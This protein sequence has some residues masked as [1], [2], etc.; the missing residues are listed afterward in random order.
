LLELVSRRIGRRIGA[1]V[2]SAMAI[3]GIG[4]LLLLLDQTFRAQEHITRRLLGSL[5]ESVATSFRSFDARTGQHPIGDISAELADYPEIEV[6][7]VFDRHGRIRWSSDVRRRG[8]MVERELLSV[9]TSTPALDAPER[10][11]DADEVRVVLPLRKTSGCLPCHD[12]SPDPIGGLAAV[13]SN[14]KLLASVISFTR[15]AGVTVFIAVVLLTALLLF[16]LNRV[17]VTRI[18]DLVAVMTK[19]EEGDFLVRAKVSSHDEIGLLA[20]TFNKMLA[21]ITDLRVER[22]ESER[23][24]GQVLGELELERELAQKTEQLEAANVRLEQRL[25]QL[26]FLNQL[27]RDLAARLDIDYLLDLLTQRIGES[28]AVPELRVILLERDNTAK[29]TKVRGLSDDLIGR[30]L[31]TKG[32]IGEAISAR[33]SI[34]V[35]NLAGDPRRTAYGADEHGSLLVVPMMYQGLATG[36]LVFSSPMADAFREDDR[37]LFATAASQAAL[38]LANAQ[39]FQETLELSLKDGLT[40][41]LNRRALESRLELEWSRALRDEAPLSVVM[42]DI[43]HFKV[44]NDQHGHQLGDETLRRVARII[45]RNIR[46]VDAVARYGGEEFAIILPRANKREA[47]EV[48]KKLRRSVE[49]ADFVR[50]YMQPLG[51]VTISAGVSTAPDDASTV[52]DL[53][54]KADESL[55]RAKQSGR[56]TIRAVGLDAED[57]VPF[58]PAAPE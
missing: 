57:S 5:A 49:Q 36:L 37:D 42:V 1:I 55:F 28:F 9:L 52:E 15:Q 27:A 7:D 50:G 41:I 48:A 13:A 33:G 26:S 10:V 43:D 23:E 21:K 22:I 3:F 54:R 39:L 56:N 51:R 35:P 34:Y 16:L 19:A 58:E 17:V 30:S 11:I 47:I 2:G 38:A 18:A 44:Y 6:L 20:T 24:M 45:E 32:A 25:K 12:K 53:V 8:K 14:R 31:D 46:K 29:I 40:G 4:G